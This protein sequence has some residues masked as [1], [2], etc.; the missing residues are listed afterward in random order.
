MPSVLG[1]GQVQ[2]SFQAVEKPFSS[3]SGNNLPVFGRVWGAKN[4][5]SAWMKAATWS[6][7]GI[8]D[9]TA[10]HYLKLP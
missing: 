2:V 4:I 8:Y 5:N 10:V 6:F 9:L 1:P 7:N 3:L